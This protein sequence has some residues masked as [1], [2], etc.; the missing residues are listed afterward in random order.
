MLLQR[1]Y[2][3]DLCVVSTKYLRYIYTVCV[4]VCRVFL[5]T[6]AHIQTNI[7]RRRVDRVYVS[8]Q[9]IFDNNR[10]SRSH[11]DVVDRLHTPLVCTHR[12]NIQTHTQV[13]NS[14]NIGTFFVV[15]DDECAVCVCV[16]VCALGAFG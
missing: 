3:R 9:N 11:H 12:V 16:F 14:T 6:H 2:G 5:H 4:C 13:L 1:S 8:R 15:C 7:S 10:T